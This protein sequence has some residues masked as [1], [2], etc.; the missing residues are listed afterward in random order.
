MHSMKKKD[1]KHTVKNAIDYTTF[2]A[3]SINHAN[4][5]IKVLKK[6]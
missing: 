6:N 1:K 3:A 5:Y 2:A 4:A